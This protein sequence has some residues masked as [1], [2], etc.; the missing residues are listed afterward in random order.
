MPATET[1]PS[2]NLDRANEL[3]WTSDLTVDEIVRE[4]GVGRSALYTSIEPIPAGADCPECGA[5]LVFTNRTNRDALSATCFQCGGEAQL[6]EAASAS[7]PSATEP[8][9]HSAERP[10]F[11]TPGGWSRWR[12]DLAA[13]SPQR[14]AIV[15]GAAALGVVFGAAAARMVQEMR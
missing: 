6:A 1:G 2:T 8:P 5:G 10:G 11:E 3:Y 4:L 14:A 7:A 15:G 9:L 13:V 12:D